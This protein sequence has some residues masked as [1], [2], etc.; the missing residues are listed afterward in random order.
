MMMIEVAVPIHHTS[1]TTST[2]IIVF[3][4]MIVQ[5]ALRIPMILEEDQLWKQC[6]IALK[7][8]SQ[9]PDLRL[10]IRLPFRRRLV[11]SRYPRRNPRG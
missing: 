9:Q 11:W 2:A 3:Q 1:S 8:T 7:L 6:T 10:S 5:S 4:S